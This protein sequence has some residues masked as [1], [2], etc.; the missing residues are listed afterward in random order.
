MTLVLSVFE[1]T[2]SFFY[3]PNKYNNQVR[4]T[5]HINKWENILGI[6]ANRVCSPILQYTFPFS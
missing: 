6:F 3:R 5:L 4:L 1:L 2:L